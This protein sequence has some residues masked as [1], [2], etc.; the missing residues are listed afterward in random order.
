MC[1]HVYAC[2]YTMCIYVFMYIYED[3]TFKHMK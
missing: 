2:M 3:K 1:V